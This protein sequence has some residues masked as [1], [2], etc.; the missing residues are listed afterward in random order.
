MLRAGIARFE[1]KHNRLPASIDEMLE[2]GSLQFEPRTP[3]PRQSW[4]YNPATG[5]VQLDPPLDTIL[6]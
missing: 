5:A 3:L 2:A 1:E 6:P 4:H